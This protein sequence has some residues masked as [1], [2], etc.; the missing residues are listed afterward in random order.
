MT[1]KPLPFAL[2][3]ALCLACGAVA[4]AEPETAEPATPAASASGD[5][6]QAAA[7]LAKDRA[8][9][10]AALAAAP[11]AERD[12]CLVRG[13]PAGD[14]RYQVI[15]KLKVARQTY[16]SVT[17]VLP[18]LAK[19]ARAAGAD[20][21]VEYNGSQRFGFFPW[22]LVRPV[23]TGTAVRWLGTQPVDCAALG[24]NTVAEVISTNKEPG[25]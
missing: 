5:E 12:L 20:L 11:S 19:E 24:G 16:G 6:A 23:A 15:K 9:A 17:L 21:I 8:E 3:A 14:A 2:A 13:K 10:E 4:A 22:R 18:E 7:A 25:K 1:K